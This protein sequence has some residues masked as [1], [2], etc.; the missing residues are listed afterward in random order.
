MPCKQGNRENIERSKEYW[1]KQREY[2]PLRE[3][4]KSLVQRVDRP[5]P[6]FSGLNSAEKLYF[7]LRVLE[8]EVYNGGFHQFF[9]NSSGEFYDQVVDGLTRLQAFASLKLLSEAKEILFGDADVPADRTERY[10]L[11]ENRPETGAESTP[12]RIRLEEIDKAYWK[13][14]DSLGAKLDEYAETQGLVEPFRREAPRD[15]G[16]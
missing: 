6:G 1:R 12:R 9:Y 8:G 10:N 14:P 11:M 2:N 7:S 15:P 16:K 5:E 3:L 13:N 4:W